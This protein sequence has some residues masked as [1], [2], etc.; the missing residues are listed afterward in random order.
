MVVTA[1]G[2]DRL[3]IVAV[4]LNHST[5]CII[6]S[7][8]FTPITAYKILVNMLILQLYTWI[9]NLQTFNYVTVTKNLRIKHE[10]SRTIIEQTD[11]KP[12]RL[13]FF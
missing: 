2:S 4:T 13:L 6:R 5:L 3:T 12:Y 8:S 1:N 11:S 9:V 7:D 10:F